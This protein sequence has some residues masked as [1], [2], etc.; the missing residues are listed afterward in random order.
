MSWFTFGK[1]KTEERPQAPVGVYKLGTPTLFCEEGGTRMEFP[2]H[3]NPNLAALVVAAN[4]MWYVV[5]K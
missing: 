4:G 1:K 2:I 3:N 5:A